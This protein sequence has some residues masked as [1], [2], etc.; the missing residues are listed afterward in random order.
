[1]IFFPKQECEEM[2]GQCIIIY[3]CLYVWNILLKYFLRLRL[4]ARIN[5]VKVDTDEYM[6]L[7][8]FSSVSFLKSGGG[9]WTNSSLCEKEPE[10]FCFIFT[11]RLL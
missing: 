6:V 7:N 1:M 3:S 4:W 5:E 11:M 8:Q 9:T 10:G 2:G